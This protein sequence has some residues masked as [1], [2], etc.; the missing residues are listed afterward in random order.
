MVS[1]EFATLELPDFGLPTV[2]HLF[3]LK[4]TKNGSGRCKVCNGGQM[5]M[6]NPLLQLPS[7]FTGIA[8]MLLT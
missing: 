8:N 4:P 6:L 7:S 3:L 5:Q 1:V 2:N